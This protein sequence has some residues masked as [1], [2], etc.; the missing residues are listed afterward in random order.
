[1]NPASKNIGTIALV[2]VVIIVLMVFCQLSQYSLLIPILL[3]SIGIYLQYLNKANL[4]LFLNFGLL[5]MLIVFIA[6]AV[7]QYTT[8][9]YY[10]IPVAGMA[11][12]TMLLFNDLQ[13][14]FLMSFLGSI[15]VSL[16]VG[17][18]FGVMLTFFIGS[19]AGS[20]AVQGARARGKLMGAGLFVS[21]THLVCLFLLNPNLQ[22]ILQR[23]FDVNYL[24]PLAANGFISVVLVIGTLKIFEYLF[25]A[26]TNYS[27]LELSDF[28]QP[29]LKRMILEAPGTYHHSLVVSNLSEAAADAIEAN[30]LLARVGAYYHDIGKMV[31]PEYF[32]ENQ[33]LGGNKHD[34]IEPSMSRLVILNHVKEGIELAK[35]NKLNQAIIDFIPQ[36]HGTSLIHYFHQKA[37]EAAEDG[38]HVDES[39]FRYPG[40]KPQARETAIVL[41][42]D[43]VEGAVRALDE[44]SPTRIEETVQK[45]INNKFIDGQLDECN[46]TLKNIDKISSTFVR[47][48]SAMYHS[49]IKYPEKKGNDGNSSRK[50]SEKSS[51]Q[52]SSDKKDSQ[53]G[54]SL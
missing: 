8:I 42:A 29:L 14:S 21:A 40:P 49:R 48:L 32:T 18:D 10:Y 3:L 23:S 38:E 5:L 17:G 16:I 24:Y 28:N 1:M 39:D 41:L 36:H 37:L 30:A 45:I 53:A 6:H 13:L 20:Y 26:L 51:S 12:L 25:G 15:L 52:P 33:L 43:S 9:P 27:L 19:L 46:L 4:K 7:T 44:Q 35:K 47:I 50:S 22:L 2:S 34:Y 54:A 11:M 31:K